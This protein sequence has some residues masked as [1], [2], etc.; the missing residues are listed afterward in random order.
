[1]VFLGNKDNYLLT[2]SYISQDFL[3]RICR[4]TRPRPQPFP[5]RCQWW[6]FQHYHNLIGHWSGVGGSGCSCFA[7][8][9]GVTPISL[10]LLLAYFLHAFLTLARR[11]LAKHSPPEKMATVDLA[12]V[13]KNTLKSENGEVR[14]LSGLWGCLAS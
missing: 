9:A 2:N 1:M 3:G 7:T 8:R 13:G 11:R 10:L 5:L 4:V 14:L 12:K 6:V